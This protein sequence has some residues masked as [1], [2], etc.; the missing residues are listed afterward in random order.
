MLQVYGITNFIFTYNTNVPEILGCVPTLTPEKAY[1]KGPGGGSAVDL[2][3]R[4]M[5]LVRG[6]TPNVRALVLRH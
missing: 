5:Y 2:S 1:T 3:E 4:M 6:R